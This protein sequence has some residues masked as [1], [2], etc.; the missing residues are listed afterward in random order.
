[1]T[2][3]TSIHEPIIE[4]IAFA[5]IEV[6]DIEASAGFYKK[7]LGLSNAPHD[8]LPDDLSGSRSMAL[9]CPSGQ[10]LVLVE[11]ATPRCFPDTGV[12]LAYRASADARDA[13]C[14][15][16]NGDAI[17]IE[18][19]HEDRPAELDDNCY[20]ADPDGNRIQIVI[21]A[22]SDREQGVLGLDHGAIQAS[23]LEWAEEFYIDQLGFLVDHRVGWKTADY[24]R[25]Q[26]WKDGKE[27]M[28]PGTRRLDQ[29]YRDIPGGK[30][31]Q[32]RAVA[33]PNMQV[34]LKMGS[35]A[36]GLYL[37]LSHEQEP[38]TDKIKGTPR[39][40]YKTSRAALD[41]M[42]KNLKS[43]Q[44]NF[45]GP[46]DIGNGTALYFRDPCGNFLELWCQKDS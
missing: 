4:G 33:R 36:L 10:M 8:A 30:P 38:S 42:A 17:P 43:S 18:H 46:E 22:S 21:D 24:I 25:A 15:S 11:R 19:Y 20:F 29:R 13:I 1:M 27:D 9:Q 39:I 5:I 37:A 6:S 16:L 40:A 12:H 34:F 7:Y 26:V 23:D 2:Q 44:G 35:T 32:G 28:A 45:L 14:Q 31:G 3:R 41:H